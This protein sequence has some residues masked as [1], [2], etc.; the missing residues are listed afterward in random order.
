[1]EIVLKKP[2]DVKE[3][4]ENVPEKDRGKLK[5][6]REIIRKAA[7]EAKEKISYNIPYY[8]YRGRLVYFALFKNHVGLLIPPP[9][10]QEHKK[11]LENYGTTKS[12]IHLPLDKKLP[13]ELI[14]KL[15]KARV[16]HN[17]EK[18]KI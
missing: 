7:P 1:M 8:E 17:E 12:S 18:N 13:V 16:R 14:K 6:I 15:I 9:I 5:E 2:K 3:Y 10:I 11:E 4:I